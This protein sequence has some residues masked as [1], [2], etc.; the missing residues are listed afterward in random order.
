MSREKNDSFE[1][2]S[3]TQDKKLIQHAPETE[4]SKDVL[5]D[6]VVDE[7][8]EQSYLAAV[9]LMKSIKCM[10]A[11]KEKA[12]MYRKIAG[13]FSQLDGYK[14]SEE[15][16]AACKK[17]VKK[18][19]KEIDK[20]TYNKALK[21]K[22]EAKSAK[23]YS[24]AAEE[25]K[26]ISGYQDADDM[27]AEC[28]GLSVAIDKKSSVKRWIRYGLIILCIAVIILG[29]GTSH[30]KYYLANAFAA[31]H[32]Y[33]TAIKIYKKLGP[34]KD[35]KERI[36]KTHYE[37]GVALGDKK[38][39]ADAEKAFAK[40]GNYKDSAAQKVK[41]E[42]QAI[43]SSEAGSLVKIGGDDWRILE[44]REGKALLMKN[45]ALPGMA[46]HDHADDITWEMS[47]LRLWLNSEFIRQTFSDQERESII[48][49]DVINADNT[50]YHTDGGNDTKDYIFLMSIDEANQYQ[51]IFP[52]FK[53]NSWLRSPG[54][55]KKTA[56]FL[57]V[58]G[59]VMDYGY[60]V[61]SEDIY[62]RPV[63]WF[64]CE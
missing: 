18:T 46:Y 6:T 27:A 26:K 36:T 41:M 44:I 48:L 34:Y 29:A 16:Y 54:S 51:P 5:N 24:E 13:D 57:S 64:N 60:D 53:S 42:K 3:E 10:T 62:V 23:E 63:M 12:D 9:S 17:F 47:S 28:S 30:A 49:S 8:R 35:C 22:K 2:L 21:L 31:T 15:C 11:C 43:K 20:N 25:F 40:A 59:T 39:Y 32:S 33:D 58:K 19:K 55:G 7:E 52:V 45:N 1:G 50:A 61:T 37:K 38:E 4:G 14:D 56:A